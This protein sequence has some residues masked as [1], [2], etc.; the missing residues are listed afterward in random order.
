MSG[1]TAGGRGFRLVLLLLVVAL[2]VLGLAIALYSVLEPSGSSTTLKSGSTLT[3][4]TPSSLT[5]SLSATIPLPMAQGRIDHMAVDAQKGLVYVADLGNNTVALVDVRSGRVIGSIGGL[6]NPQGVAFIPDSGRSLYV[7]NAGD[8]SVDVFDANSLK[9][10]GRISLAADADNTRYDAG[11]KLLYV[12]YGDGGIAVVNTTTAS[13]FRTFP[14]PAHPEAFQVE[15]NGSLIY[16]NDPTTGQIHVLDKLTG[17]SVGNVTI[18]SGYK[19]NFPMALDERDGRLFV[20]TRSPSKLLVFDTA[21]WRT[22]ATIDIPG[23]PDD[24]FYDAARGLVLVSCG[25][26]SL[27]VI[28]QEDPNNYVTLQSI[29]T[30]PGARTSLFVPDLGFIVVGV[31]PST[32]QQAELL[33]YS[34]SQTSQES[35]SMSA[36]QQRAT[37]P[38]SVTSDS[39]TI[40][41]V[42]ESG[43]DAG[44]GSQTTTGSGVS[45]FIAY[46]QNQTLADA[47]Y[48]GRAFVLTGAVNDIGTNHN[49]TYYACS[50]ECQR[51]E[52]TGG[53]IIWYWSNQGTAAEVP[54]GSDTSFTARCTVGGLRNGDL[55][56]DD[57]AIVSIP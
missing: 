7:S 34:L 5:V 35:G 48:G 19:D 13:L 10:V 41:T 31:P 17:R 28:R 54:V 2:I 49:G 53:Q 24:I 15:A 56:L 6:D 25:Q 16:I 9:P 14:L 18:P 11:M 29:A 52:I 50:I 39:S 22:V 33:V 42:G 38:S 46:R 44:E 4:G 57:C 20:G 23:D 3:A 30:G 36:T 40:A 27:Q 26:G 37:G 8:G 47:E 51:I 43:T 12:G 21:S 55:V 45:L 1:K 32:G